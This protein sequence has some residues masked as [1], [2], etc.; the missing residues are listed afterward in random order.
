MVNIKNI[1]QQNQNHSAKFQANDI[2][3]IYNRRF[4]L[5]DRNKNKPN[6]KLQ[7]EDFHQSRIYI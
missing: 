4:I 2:G 6:G 5:L 1:Y 7:L 3:F